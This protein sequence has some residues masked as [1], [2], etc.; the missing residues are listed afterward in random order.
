MNAAARS[1]IITTGEAVSPEVIDGITEALSPEL[2][3]Q[4]PPAIPKLCSTR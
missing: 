3:L 2:N 1:A 4:L